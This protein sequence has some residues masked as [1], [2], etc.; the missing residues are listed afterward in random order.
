MQRSFL[1][2]AKKLRDPVSD[3]AAPPINDKLLVWRSF[4]SA[5]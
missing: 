4:S 5:I 1:Q 2:A 3:E